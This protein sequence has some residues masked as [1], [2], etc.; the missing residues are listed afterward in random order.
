[1]GFVK[2]SK[3][4][5]RYVLLI[6]NLAFKFPYF[7]S[8]KT[9]LLGLLGNMQEVEFSKVTEMKSKLCPIKFY[10]PLGFLVVMPKVRI[11]VNNELSK[12]YL[13]KFCNLET[14]VIP[15]EIKSDSFGY[16]RDKLVVVDF[17]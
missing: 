4:S 16:Y 5:S 11:L 3:G 2:V 7:Y 15:A 8:W 14:C 12:D 13:E 10:L 6:G 1:M 9:F 17:G